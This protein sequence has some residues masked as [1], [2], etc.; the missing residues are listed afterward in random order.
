MSDAQAFIAN[1]SRALGRRETAAPPPPP[2]L[3]EGLIRTLAGH[4]NLS[5]HFERQAQ[6]SGMEVTTVELEQLVDRLIALLRDAGVSKAALPVSPLLDSLD[7]A[8]QLRDA[9]IHAQRWDELTADAVFDV[10]CGVTDCDAAIAE[11]GSVVIKAKPA[12][13]RV[14]SVV[15]P[16]HVVIVEPRRI[17]ADLLD[18]LRRLEEEGVGSGTVVITGP[19]KTTDIEGNLVIGVHG[20]GRVHIFLLE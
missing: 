9:G 6:A 15:P 20:P 5:R 8:S 17:V 12:H 13:G 18:V 16:L 11:T 7:L 4:E 1:V 3:D 14:L 10:D 2:T 19:S